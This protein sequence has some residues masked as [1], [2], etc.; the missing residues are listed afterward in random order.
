LSIECIY[1]PTK[2]DHE[3]HVKLVRGPESGDIA[4]YKDDAKWSKFRQNDDKY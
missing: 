1:K 3:E 4:V 2:E